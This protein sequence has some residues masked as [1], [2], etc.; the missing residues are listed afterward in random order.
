M[1]FINHLFSVSAFLAI[2]ALMACG[3]GGGGNPTQSP[4]APSIST[5][6]VSQT[7]NA[8]AT[9]TFSVTASGTAPLSY[10]WNKGG[11]AIPGATLAT[12]TTSATV[13]GDNG[14][15][16]TA[17]ISNSGGSVTSS[18]AILTVQ[19]LATTLAYTDPTSGTYILKK[20]VA[21]STPSHLVLDLIGPAATTGNGVAAA[22]TADANKVTWANVGASDPTSTFVQNGTAFSLGTAPQILKGKVTGS[23]LQVAAAQKG[24]SSPA[25]LN[26][27]LLRIALD[28]KAAQPAGTVALSADATKCQVLDSAGIITPIVVS[29]GTLT[30]Q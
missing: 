27:P 25:A 3:G 5:Q 10:Q 30:A 1:R 18:A 14:S 23:S 21:L 13:A 29:V 8:G 2:A 12:Y 6:P 26:A 9:A 7:V 28:L 11:S 20:N 22:F 24:V 4:V 16:F 15:S 19:T 17:T